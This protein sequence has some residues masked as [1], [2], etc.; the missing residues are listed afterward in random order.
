MSSTTCSWSVLRRV[1]GRFDPFGWALES[2]LDKE[3]G[4]V[5]VAR[6]AFSFV[7]KPR[8]LRL[9]T[10]RSFVQLSGL[11]CVRR[12]LRSLVEPQLWWSLSYPFLISYLFDDTL[13]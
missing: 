7:S 9:Y 2:G 4:K 3:S 13:D 10:T 12:Y 1:E 5:L 11:S 6:K 8:M